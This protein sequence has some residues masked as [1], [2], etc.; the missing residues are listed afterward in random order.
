MTQSMFLKIQIQIQSMFLIRSKI[1]HKFQI[2]SKIE[3]TIFF[4]F[5]SFFFQLNY[6]ETKNV[7]N[8]KMSPKKSIEQY[9]PEVRWHL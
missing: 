5:L 7:S 6:F 1:H 3:I 2:D 4:F 8:R 9:E